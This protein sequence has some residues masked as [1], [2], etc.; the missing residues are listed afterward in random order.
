MIDYSIISDGWHELSGFC[1]CQTS[2]RYQDMI[3]G[4]IVRIDGKDYLCY[5]D[6]H[7]GY[8]SHSELKE[9]E[10]QCT[11]TFPP[12]R[13]MVKHFET[14]DDKYI[15]FLS[16][17]FERILLIGTSHIDDYYPCAVYE[18]HPENLPINKGVHKPEYMMPGEVTVKIKDL[19]TKEGTSSIG[20]IMDVIDQ[21]Y[22]KSYDMGR[23]AVLKEMKQ[24]IGDFDS[25]GQ[26]W[27]QI[28]DYISAL[29]RV[30]TK[31][32]ETDEDYLK[33]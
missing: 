19:L 8:R 26:E 27:S 21:Y 16:P 18:W 31:I 29:D 11:N 15:E 33:S 32:R 9:T 6:P 2:D 12:Q 28:G 13:I 24:A 25:Y 22:R 14:T 4:L 10:M 3:N 1:E 17:D 20:E 7:D 30:V 23:E 5:E